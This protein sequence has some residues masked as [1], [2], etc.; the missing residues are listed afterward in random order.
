MTEYQ[1]LEVLNGMNSNSMA[2]QA[3]FFTALSAYLFVAYAI[4]EKLSTFQVTFIS[5][6]FLLIAFLGGYTLSTIMIQTV[7]YSAQLDQVRGG[8]F[9]RLDSGAESLIFVVIMTRLLMA[10]GALIF[11]WSIRHPKTA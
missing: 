6:V 11:M 2:V 7:D 5:V 10:V 8:A 4:G 9:V 1:L 3:L